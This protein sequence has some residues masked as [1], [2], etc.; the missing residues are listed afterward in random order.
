MG[1][2]WP[3]RID[4]I[5]RG[6]S[7][8]KG[9]RESKS[10]KIRRAE[11]MSLCSRMSNES[12]VA[13]AAITVLSSVLKLIPD[14]L[15]GKT[16][17]GRMLL[18]PFR[19]QAP[20]VLKDGAGYTYRMPSYAEPTA[21]HIFTF[22]AYERETQEA[23]LKFLPETGTFIDVG[24]NVG[25][26][27]IPIGKK[28]PQA[29]VICIE[30]DS[31]IHRFLLENLNRNGCERVEVVPCVAGA[32]D[33]QLVAF[34]RAPDDKFGMGSLGPQFCNVP[35]MVQQQ[36]LDNI[37][38]CMDVHH[39]DVIKIDVEG[40]EEG[41]LRGAQRLLASERPPTVIF[42]FADWAEARIPGQQPGDA[43]AFLLARGYRLFRLERGGVGEELLAPMRRGFAMLL[44]VPMRFPL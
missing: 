35:V 31:N 3:L 15:P 32:T 11:T 20:A 37:L 6:G 34:Y 26:L 5:R 7:A 33:G 44:A 39:V 23:I 1:V 17:L 14:R 38:S 4:R 19:S 24:A 22:G 27:A 30:A 43:Q 10:P 8:N 25:T 28:R 29:S 9:G 36:S 2:I 21:L 12:S 13:E 40:A 42:E 18:R 41:V 16:R